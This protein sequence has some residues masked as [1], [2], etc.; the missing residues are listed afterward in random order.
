MSN[1]EK[2]LKIPLGRWSFSRYHV[3]SHDSTGDWTSDWL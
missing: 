2:H 1:I 3:I